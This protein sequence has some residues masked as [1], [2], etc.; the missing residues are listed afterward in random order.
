[1]RRA[2]TLVE[3]KEDLDLVSKV[4]NLDEEMRKKLGEAVRRVGK[5]E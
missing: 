2:L 5:L 1:M 4:Q 3:W